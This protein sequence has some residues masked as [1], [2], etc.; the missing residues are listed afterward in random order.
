VFVRL[1]VV[2]LLEMTAPEGISRTFARSIRA[3]WELKKTVIGIFL[4]Y[5]FQL[6]LSSLSRSATT[7][8]REVI[9]LALSL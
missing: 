3:G 5:I 7:Y 8:T 9:L 2:S 1:A 4:D 6:L